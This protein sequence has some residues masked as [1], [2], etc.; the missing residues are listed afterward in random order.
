MPVPETFL[1]YG[2]NNL[3]SPTGPNNPINF[4]GTGNRDVTRTA[5]LHFTHGWRY[6]SNAGVHFWIDLDGKL[7]QNNEADRCWRHV[8]GGPYFSANNLVR[9]TSVAVEVCRFGK[10]RERPNGQWQVDGYNGINFTEDNTDPEWCDYSAMSNTTGPM[11]FNL[12][13][14]PGGD[15]F[16]NTSRNYYKVKAA[17]FNDNR[18]PEKAR[19]PR[20]ILFS[21]EQLAT[22]VLWLKSILEHYRIPKRFLCDPDSGEENPWIDTTVLARSTNAAL[23]PE[24]IERASS[25]QGVWGHMNLQDSRVDPGASM[26]YY[27]LKRGISD[28]WWYPVNVDASERALNYLDSSIS[29]D[30]LALKEYGSLDDLEQHYRL[31]ESGNA[32]FYPIGLNRIWHGGIHLNSGTAPKPVYAMANGWIVAARVTNGQ[33]NGRDLP[34]SRCFVLIKHLV[35]TAD[36]GQEISYAANA[37]NTIY[38]LYMHLAPATLSKRDDG[39]G[40]ERWDFDYDTLPKWLCHFLIDN[41]TITGVDT[42]GLI[43]PNQKVDLSDHLGG[44]GRYI[45]D[46]RNLAPAMGNTVHVEVFGTDDP[47][48]FGTNPWSEAANRIIDPTPD[49]VVAD[50]G[51]LDA[52]IRDAGGD[53][54]DVA[55][56]K[57]AAPVMR[58]FAI[59]SRSEWSLTAKTQLGDHAQ[60][61]SDTE[62]EGLIRPLC[63]QTDI[64]ADAAANAN[65]IGPFHGTTTVW[66]YHPFRFLQWM[67]ER[68]ERHDQIL[69]DQDKPRSNLPSNI[70]VTDGYVTGFTTPLAQNTGA[71]N[72]PEAQYN[73]NTYEVTLDKLAD[74]QALTSAGQ[75]Q[76]RFNLR[77]LEALDICNDRQHGLQIV[78]GYVSGATV[79]C[80]DQARHGLHR[81]GD[82]VDI[83]PA[84]STPQDWYNL[85][86]TTE[87]ARTYLEEFHDI[88]LEMLI[89][90]DTSAANPTQAELNQEADL[91]LNRIQQASDA[92][93]AVLNSQPAL[94]HLDRLRLHLSAP[95]G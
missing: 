59:K 81:S 5:T 88:T 78:E 95:P 8:S 20:D 14:I 29:A 18:N 13:K 68:V 57:N 32:G 33:V 65:D 15:T 11:K 38:S 30:Y 22:L 61:V 69:A 64:A 51:T 46:V 6:N 76:T 92:G 90:A 39:N 84:N 4:A 87:N 82:A 60:S 89:V 44:T 43:Y 80:S 74:Q 70:T 54:I 25:H 3:V 28:A 66:H 63:F 7:F 23:R 91:L 37:V 53:G 55:D 56:I 17:E 21:E 40:G 27:R 31:N 1:L 85:Y 19:Y 26:D 58:S 42:G 77:L 75:N 86:Q 24:A 36:N 35:H 62:W 41:P 47:N 50:R 12:W 52:V 9:N 34:Y 79:Q 73:E 67:N 10:F 49:D 48:T 2:Q 94:Q 71:V 16:E 93:D 72:Y 45:T 83:R